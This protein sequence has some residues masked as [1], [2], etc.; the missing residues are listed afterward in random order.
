MVK[1]VPR[2]EVSGGQV[3]RNEVVPRTLL[4]YVR[5]C[6]LLD[7]SLVW[8]SLIT[9]ME[10]GIKNKERPLGERKWAWHRKSRGTWAGPCDHFD[11]W[12]GLSSLH[13]LKL[14]AL[15]STANVQKPGT[16]VGGAGLSN[17]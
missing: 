5:R 12:V 10:H 4:D 1:I 3:I 8:V 14:L 13:A 15:Q 11:T 17:A 16:E 9:G 7:I 2:S 6:L